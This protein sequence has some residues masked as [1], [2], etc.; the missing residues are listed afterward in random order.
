MNFRQLTYFFAVAEHLHFGRAAA[1]LHV[2]QASVSEAV[3]ALEQSL[4][5]ALFHRTTRRVTLTPFGAEFLAAARPAWDELLRAHAAARGDLPS[6]GELILAHTPELGHLVLPSLAGEARSADLATP[7]DLWRP[8][9]MHTHQQMES[10]GGG[11]VDL[12]L[13]WIPTVREPLVATPLAS[14]PFVVIAPEND[15]LAERPDLTLADLRSRRIVVS[16]R[17]VNQF[18]DA[19]LQSAFVQAGVSASHVDEVSGYDQVALLVATRGAIGIHPASIVGVNRVPGV[20]FRRLREPGLEIEVS[21]LHRTADAERL[22]GLIEVLR[23][24]TTAS[25]DRA[26][27]ALDGPPVSGPAPAARP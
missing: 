20:V 10:I 27:D 17:Q 21:A 5:G 3:K 23:R 1:S 22:R 7:H 2:G 18:I 4:G 16:S 19:R 9:S 14:C 6:K 11:T 15:P 26:M 24:V 13:C 12:G 25:I 8:V